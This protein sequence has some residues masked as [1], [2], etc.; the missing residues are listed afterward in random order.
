MSFRD[1]LLRSNFFIEIYFNK[2][3]ILLQGVVLIV[4]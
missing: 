4:V 2:I 3:S 1:M